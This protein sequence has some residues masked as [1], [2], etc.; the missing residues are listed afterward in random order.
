MNEKLAVSTAAGFLFSPNCSLKNYRKSQKIILWLLAWL[1]EKGRSHLKLMRLRDRRHKLRVARIDF[2]QINV[3]PLRCSSS[4]RKV[5]LGIIPFALRERL[6]SNFKFLFISQNEPK[7]R[8]INSCGLL[9]FP[10]RATVQ[11]ETGLPLTP[12]KQDKMIFL[13]IQ[14]PLF[15]HLPQFNAQTASFNRK[16]IGKLLARI[17]DIKLGAAALLRHRG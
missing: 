1:F 10:L 16:I 6:W 14:Q 12:L 5:T 7:A 13:K 2:P 17:W 3:H 11:L 4:P 15:A 9:V 8:S